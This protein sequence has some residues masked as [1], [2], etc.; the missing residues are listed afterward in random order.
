MINRDILGFLRRS[1]HM[2]D[3]PARPALLPIL[4]PTIDAFSA[5][6]REQVQT[7]AF[8]QTLGAA[9]EF[10]DF[11]PFGSEPLLRLPWGYIIHLKASVT[12]AGRTLDGTLLY[13]ALINPV[14]IEFYRGAAATLHMLVGGTSNL[15]RTGQRSLLV[16][17]NTRE[18][19][20]IGQQIRLSWGA[21]GAG[22][23]SS[24][25]GLL[26]RF[27]EPDDPLRWLPT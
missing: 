12:G 21:G 24:V 25:T 20:T 10:H 1:L 4:H 2:A 17:T 6:C 22:E 8:T 14:G 19:H 7:F 18:D 23:T 11:E 3:A 15:N 5:T 26:L 27:N 13:N 9:A 16:P